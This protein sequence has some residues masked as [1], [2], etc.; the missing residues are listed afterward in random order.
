MIKMHKISSEL[1]IIN[2]LGKVDSKE[3]AKA[4][5]KQYM[6]DEQLTRILK[7]KHPEVLKRIA[8]SIV[9]CNPASIFV[10]TGSSEDRQFINNL[11]LAKKE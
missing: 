5:F 7:I 2:E 4:I 3:S 10:N 9:I 1:D 8:N 11:S 6:D